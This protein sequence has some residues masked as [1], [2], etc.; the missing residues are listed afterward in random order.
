MT[1]GRLAVVQI[2]DSGKRLSARDI[3]QQ[4]SALQ[5]TAGFATVYRALAVLCTAGLV[6]KMPSASGALYERQQDDSLPQL[7]CSRCGRVEDIDD[8]GLLRYNASVI[9]SRSLPERDRLLLYAD[10]KRKGCA[11]ND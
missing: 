7:I 5:V 10:C 9:K 2:L 1:P 11:D 3:W 6:R 4:M 8:P